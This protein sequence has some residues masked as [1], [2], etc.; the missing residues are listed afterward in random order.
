[1]SRE[2]VMTQPEEFRI[3]RILVIDDSPAIH[4]D[5]R[6][7]LC[8]PPRAGLGGGHDTFFGPEPVEP[9]RPRYEIHSAFQGEEGFRKVQEAAAAGR[10]YVLAFVDSRMPPGWDGVEAVTRI[11]QEQPNLQIVFCTANSDYSWDDLQ[12][13]LGRSP[14]LAILKKPFDL[15]EVL[16]IASTASENYALHERDRHQSLELTRRVEELQSQLTQHEPTQQELRKLWRAVE[17]TPATILMTDVTGKIEYV[18]PRFVEITGYSAAEAL[19]Q[20]PRFLKS[21]AH[22]PA[23]YRH[24]WETLGQGNVWQG[25]LCNKKKNGELYWESACISPVRDSKETITHYIAVKE[26]ITERRRAAEALRLAEKQLEENGRQQKAILDNISDPA[27]LRGRKGHFLMVNR[28]WCE[29]AGMEAMQAVGKTVAEV[30]MYPPGVAA[31][32]QAE[33]EQV[34]SSGKPS[35]QEVQLTFP[36]TGTVWFETSKAALIDERGIV[37]GLVGIARNISAHKQD[38]LALLESQRFLQSALNALSAHIAILDQHGLIIEVNAA[39]NQ[40][41]RQNN[42]LGGD[43][44]IGAN[45]LSLCESATGVCA[46]EAPAVAEGI[47]D[48]MGGR[49]AEFQLEYPCHSPQE[50]RW[51]VV[52]VTRFAGDGPVR[53]VIAHENITA[54]KRAEEE[55]QWKTAFL[56]AQVNSS[57]DGI[58]VVDDQG[59]KTLQNQR[60][61]DLL[62]IPQSIAD[63]PDDEVQRRWVTQ[64]SKNPEQFIARV[65]HLNSHRDEI[66]RDEMEMKDG[67]VLDRYS[68]P[69]VGSSGKYYGRIWTFRDI[70]E[71]KRADAVL[72]EQLLL[73]ER[74]AKIATNAPGIIYAFRLRPDGSVCLPYVSPTIEEFYGVRADGLADDASPVFDLI[75]PED[76]TRMRKSITESARTLSPWRC[77]FRVRHPRKGLFWVEGQATPERET[78]GGVL[79]H[80]FMSDITERK[81]MEVSLRES[82][83]KFRQLAEN[84][85]DVFWITSPDL[86]T[87]HYVSRCYV[88][89]WGRST[90]S[91]Y[92]NPHEWVEAILPE[93]RERV[94]TAFAGLMDDVPYVDMEYRIARP[95]GAIRW[96]QDRGF[97]VRDAGGKL[98]R[99]AGIASDITER[100]QVAEQLVLAKEAADSANRAKSEFLATMSHEIRTPMNGLLGFT[101]LLI[102]SP[103]S[104]EQSQF[105]QAIKLSGKTLLTLINDILDY[106]KIEAGKLTV[107]AIPFDLSQVVQEVAGLIAMQAQQKNLAFHVQCESGLPPQF[108]GD[109]C[110]VRQVLLNLAGNAVKFTRQG[111]ITIRLKP[112]LAQSG[113]VR[114]EITDTGVGISADNQARLFQPF[115]Q[116]DSSTTRKYGGTGLGLAISKQ[117]VELMGGEIGLNSQPNQGSTF[118]FT[119]PATPHSQVAVPN[120]ELPAPGAALPEVAAKPDSQSSAGLRVLLAE[121]NFMNQKLAVHLLAKLNCRIDVAN[122]GLEA[123]E[124]AVR[125]PY[126]LIFMDCLMPEMD[127]WAATRAIRRSENGTGRVPIIA[128]TAHV[129]QEQR[130]KCRAAGMDDF[131]EKPIQGPELGG[132]LQKWVF[133]ARKRPVANL[134]QGTINYET[135]SH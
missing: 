44:G 53:V 77:E 112:A 69:L 11:W 16:Q 75:H 36:D 39:W 4:E 71:R 118:W 74:L 5:F 34:M 61:A 55:L 25:E 124:L 49:C 60:M 42:F 9:P 81:R 17:Q 132:A 130:E 97:Q 86:K 100:K 3:N 108:T 40:F 105:A 80:G 84:I 37:Y 88:R 52:R 23:F 63:D 125:R 119:L 85:T 66:S 19:G 92:A 56:E 33:D 76:Q 107:E 67:T 46:A 116:A 1:M 31:Q 104:D 50:Q 62:G 30:G 106:S 14:N 102:E 111:G 120:L 94:F 45:Y 7:I 122:N 133:D 90:E 99:L 87:M 2:T 93:E 78:D 95:D 135:V 127:G 28:A 51:F 32:L 48:I 38:K 128:I 21:G 15:I 114:C 110:R 126:D 73:R 35:R 83:E 101:N 70:T 64:A 57:I 103:L 65:L 27:W 29:F 24:M 10:P 109:P 72:K 26:D 18:N 47:R 131:I 8:G 134:P 129:N 59:G 121:D 13:R 68:A 117:L 22:D 20:N 41:A 79:W 54:R 6:K 98:I 91:L 123:V 43:Y 96:I 58:L 115:S 89:V 12:A 113:F 82:D